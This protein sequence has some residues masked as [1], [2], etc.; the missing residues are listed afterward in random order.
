MDGLSFDLAG[1]SESIIA[2]VEQVRVAIQSTL[3]ELQKEGGETTNVNN[4]LSFSFKETWEAI[5]GTAMLKKFVSD[6]VKV[7]GEFQQL[8]TSFSTLLQDKGEVDALMSQMMK[9]ATETPFSVTELATGAQQLLSYGLQAEEVSNTLTQLGNVASGSGLPLESL[10]S[11]YGTV[12]SQG[13]LYAGDLEKFTSSGVPMLQG[14]ADMYGVTTAKVNEMVVAGQIGFPEVQTVIGNLTSEGGEFYN[15]MNEQSNTITGKIDNLGDAWNIMLNKIGQSQEGVISGSLDSI[16]YLV[17]NYEEFGR[18]LIGLISVYG[19]YKV[20]TMLAIAT[21]NGYTISQMAQYSILLLVEKAQKALNLTVLKNPYV[22]AA[23]AIVGLVSAMWALADRTS[24]AE[25]EQEKLNEKT[26]RYNEQLKDEKKNIN[27]LLAILQDETATQKDKSEAFKE[28]QKMM[29]SVYGTYKT[30]KE[31]LDNLIEARKKENEEIRIRGELM[32]VENMNNSVNELSELKRLKE[33]ERVGGAGRTRQGTE[34]EYQNL[35]SQYEVRNKKGF[36]QSDA[37]YI[38]ELIEFTSKQIGNGQNIIRKQEQTAW[39]STLNTMSRATAEGQKKMYQ[40]YKILLTQS[41]KEWIQIEGSTSPING[42]IIADRISKLNR[43]V[44]LVEEKDAAQYQDEA[45]KAW[46]KAKKA[47]EDIKSSKIK[48]RSPEQFEDALLK[49]QQKEN[50]AKK[51]YESRGGIVDNGYKGRSIQP[52]KQQEHVEELLGNQALEQRLRAEGLQNQIDQA[53]IDAMGEGSIKTL[54]QMQ[55]NHRKEQQELEREMEDTL[56]KKKDADGSNIS[57]S[58]EEQNAFGQRKMYLDLKQ[59]REEQSPLE[60]EEQAWNNY[61]TEYGSFQEKKDAISAEYNR[62][63]SESSVKGEKASLEKEKQNKLKDV[64]FE[65]LKSSINFADVFGNLDAQSTDAIARMRDKLKEVIDE[66]AQD[67][68]PTDLKALQDALKEMD[69]KIANR[70]PFSGLKNGIDDYKKSTKAVIKAQEDLNAVQ[71]GGEIVVGT[72]V[73][74][75]GKICTKLLTQEQAEKKLADAQQ[76]RSEAQVLLT[77]S[78]NSIGEKGRELVDSGKEICDMLTNLG[79]EVPEAVSGT[80]EGLG[81]V[82][83]SLANVDFTNPFSIVKGI[84][85]AIGGIGKAIGSLFN[86]DG[87]KEKNIQR[88]QGQIDALDGSY[89]NLNSSI[90]KAYSTDASKL[91]SQQ[92]E[93]LEQQ[94]VLI[95]NQIAEEQSK[96]NADDGRIEEWQNQIESINKQIGENKEKQVDAILGS[97]VKSAIDEFAQAYADAW[98]GG[99]DRAKSSKDLV[100]DMIKQ[101]V[102]EAIKLTSSEPMKKLRDKLAGFFSDGIVSA[103]ERE[104]IEKDAE[105]IMNDLDSKYGWADEYM[106]DDEESTSQADSSKGGFETMSQ[107]TGMELNGRFTALQISNEE[108]KNSMLLM[109]GNLSSLCT[110]TTD[111]NIL[112]SEMRNLAVMSNGHLEDIA[113][114]TKVLLGFGEKLDKIEKNTKGL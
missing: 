83:D 42:Q 17:E 31:L 64:G 36:F 86:D 109:L 5:D 41:G 74:A 8:E 82:V 59:S 53:R 94:K 23:V 3:S 54:A 37:S 10:A 7:R 96:K 29:P 102:M 105:A 89:D 99:D 16:K 104:Q 110:T 65:E 15:L 81:K 85:G 1:N 101:M 63:I 2:K 103:W 79:I 20:A 4:K 28:L 21:S 112:L 32:N 69:L 22:I 30:E 107:E 100:K 108:I 90:E 6:V 71:K 98:A 26:K 75:T 35:Y 73:D 84:A 46:D 39:E 62:K 92:N 52:S 11:L 45:K 49:A 51:T 57:L 14:L 40:G 55:L 95:Q 9:M 113:K 24:T 97:D 56:Q 44:L 80:L 76:M 61:L 114:H 72:Y 106:K 67:L 43:E 111:G 88:L 50:S 78:V 19:T 38:D 60:K 70:D 34:F 91:I 27:G 48:Y 33:L 58:R 87:K 18:V 93:L 47:V 77:Q 13:S 25:K 66:S 68:R 12:L